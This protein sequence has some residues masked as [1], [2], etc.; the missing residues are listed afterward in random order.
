MT[1]LTGERQDD[2]TTNYPIPC[3][4]Y[5]CQTK[6][7]EL[8][9]DINLNKTCWEVVIDPSKGKVLV[10]TRD[11]KPW[12]GVLKDT[13]L[14]TA[15]SSSPVCLGCL[16]PVS[17]EVVCTLC[18][19][20]LCRQECQEEQSHQEECKLFKTSKIAPVRDQLDRSLGIYSFI[21]VLRVLLLKEKDIKAWKIIQEMMDH[22]EERPKDRKVVEGVAT[23]TKFFQEK[24]GLTWVTIE[25]VCHVYG[26]LKTNAV[27]L[28]S[29]HAQALYPVVCILSHSC[30]AN[31]EPVRDP[32][33]VIEFRAKR[34]IKKGEELTMRYTDFLDSRRNIQKKINN[35][36]IFTCSCLR[37]S[38]STEFGSNFSSFQCYCGGYYHEY[39]S[40]SEK[41]WKC[42]SCLK[43]RDLED[44]YS[45][46]D[47]LFG[48]ITNHNV[49]EILAIIEIEKGGY[50]RNFYLTTQC[51]MKYLE[52]N[53]MSED[54]ETVRCMVDRARVVLETLAMVDEG[55]TRLNGKFLL[56]L[57]TAQQKL[58]I[59]KR[60]KQEI[61]GMEFRA[62]MMEITKAKLQAAKMISPFFI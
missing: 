36:W 20:P 14:I 46:A 56:I 49:D 18:K 39:G 17:G 60:K 25:D 50:H 52:K 1:R 29:G 24:L 41:N 13:A 30:A 3:I 15:P 7:D 58:L 10:A 33:S 57:L 53:K 59:I 54:E 38:D 48:S 22:W 61:E 34:M 35:E 2:K 8:R 51:Y 37:C 43:E 45:E 4:A 6:E 47:Q 40:S 26:V 21:S 32:S 19:W 55:C 62:A 5:T 44:K 12:E 16:V 27:G 42:S 11:I 28:M 23:M 31:L 9:S